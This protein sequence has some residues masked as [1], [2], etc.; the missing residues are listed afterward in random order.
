MEICR[1]L[2]C[3]SRN[4]LGPQSSAVVRITSV[5]QTH[6]VPSPLHFDKVIRLVQLS[7]PGH[8]QQ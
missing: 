5:L 4:H 6:R 2:S 8:L 1:A 3:S 7:K